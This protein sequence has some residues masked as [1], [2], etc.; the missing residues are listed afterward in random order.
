MEA[1]VCLYD[2]CDGPDYNDPDYED[3]DP[4]YPE[5]SLWFSKKIPAEKNLKCCECGDVIPAGTVYEQVDA[6]YEGDWTSFH[7][8]IGCMR[9][10]DDIFECGFR[11]GGLWEDLYE[12]WSQNIEAE[13]EAEYQQALDD[14][15]EMC[16]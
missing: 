9:V 5:E 1:C 12:A 2:T 10:R 7:T 16:H 14:L 6:R 15:W 13:T 8:C 3:Y 4:N 11:H